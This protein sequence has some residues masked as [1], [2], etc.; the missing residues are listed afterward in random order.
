MT[1]A[2]ALY[3]YV[4]L[5]RKIAH[6][7]HITV[8]HFI[9]GLFWP[10]VQLMPTRGQPQS[11]LQGQDF[12]LDFMIKMQTKCQN[13]LFWEGSNYINFKTIN[14]PFPAMLVFL[15]D[16]PLKQKFFPGKPS[17]CWKWGRSLILTDR[18]GPKQS[19]RLMMWYCCVFFLL[20]SSWTFY[21]KTSLI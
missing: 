17:L 6:K 14:G 9:Y 2:L 12:L 10:L 13:N 1:L 15:P 19:P 21:K 16:P 18:Q 3:V 5:V 4:H 7:T 11:N 20:D 8:L